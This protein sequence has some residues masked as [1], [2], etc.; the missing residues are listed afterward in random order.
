MTIARI[1]H[2]G[3]QNLTNLGRGT[4]FENPLDRINIFINLRLIVDGSLE[5]LETIE[6]SLTMIV[7]TN[8]S[9]ELADFEGILF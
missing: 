5:A 6:A 9:T 2:A 1:V 3:V 8:T 4:A 7:G